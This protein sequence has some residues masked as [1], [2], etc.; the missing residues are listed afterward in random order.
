MYWPFLEVV[1][2]QMKLVRCLITAKACLMSL[3]TCLDALVARPMRH[4]ALCIEGEEGRMRLVPFPI[5][6]D[7]GS[8]TCEQ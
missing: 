3:M 1:S 7:G 4:V 8:L 6:H 2:C 5:P